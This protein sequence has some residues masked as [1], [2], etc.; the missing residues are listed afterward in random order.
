MANSFW[1]IRSCKKGS[2]RPQV[3]YICRIEGF[4]SRTDLIAAGCG[5]LPEWAK[6]DPVHFFAA[7]DQFERKNAAVCRH[8]V[9]SLP[10]ELSQEVLNDVVRRGIAQ[11]L[12]AKPYVYAIHGPHSTTDGETQPHAHI[13]YSDRL[14][15]EHQRDAVEHFRRYNPKSPQLGGCK[16]A[17]GG[18]ST[19]ELSIALTERKN[20][21]ASVQNAALTVSGSSDRV[22]YRS[23]AS[24]ALSTPTD[25]NKDEKS[26]E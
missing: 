9:V 21:W 1:K 25:S 10:R 17:S 12:G 14:G 22:D 18:Q 7:A 4:A 2:A 15:D 5:N 26:G 3:E 8:I 11:D 16:K 23:K 24:R 19:K 13:V 20:V 6:D